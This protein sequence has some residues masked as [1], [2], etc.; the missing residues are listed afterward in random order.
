MR[1]EVGFGYHD[2]MEDK[3][4]SVSKTKNCFNTEANIIMDW[5]QQFVKHKKLNRKITRVTWQRCYPRVQKGPSKRLPNN[6][7]GG[8]FQFWNIRFCCQ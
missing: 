1:D 5:K 8:W 3:V 7:H 2:G 4:V 6:V